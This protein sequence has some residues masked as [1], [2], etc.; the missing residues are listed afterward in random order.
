MNSKN[1]NVNKME[2][3]NNIIAIFNK[4]YRDNTMPYQLAYKDKIN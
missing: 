1:K 4:F 3:D 2:S